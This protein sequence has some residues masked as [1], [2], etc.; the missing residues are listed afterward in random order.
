[1]DLTDE[2]MSESEISAA[3][4]A[5]R[6][7]LSDDLDTLPEQNWNTP[8]GG[9]GVARLAEGS[10]VVPDGARHRPRGLHWRVVPAAA[11]LRRPA[12]TP[13]GRVARLSNRMGVPRVLPSVVP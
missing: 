3:I 1:M 9:R 12:K 4:K 11:T 7:N 2:P 8:G 10:T 6:L 5:E 13:A